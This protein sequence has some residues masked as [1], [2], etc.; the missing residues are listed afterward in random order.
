MTGDL[1]P[2]ELSE[3]K[4]RIAKAQHY[5]QENG[6]GALYLNA[7]TNLAYFTGMQWYASER[8]VGALLPAKGDVVYLAPTFE[9]DSLN[10][11][12]LVE[13][14]I[15][16]WQ[17]HESPYALVIAMLDKLNTAGGDKLG[18]DE[19]TQFFIVDGLNKMLGQSWQIINGHQIL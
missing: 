12:K 17:E 15:I 6:I 8:L 2:I 4:A 14:N 9:I 5:M 1:R 10:E 7:G 11:R 13:G 19:S 3:Y 18:V 16:G